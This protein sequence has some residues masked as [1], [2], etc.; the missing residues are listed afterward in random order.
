[1]IKS[2]ITVAVNIIQ[3]KA[4]S[5]LGYFLSI[6]AIIGF[7]IEVS[8]EVKTGSEGFIIAIVMFI[9][10]VL[11]IL[12]GIEIK[13]R[14]KRFR[15]YVSL[16][17]IQNMT[18][19][20]D[21]A[22]NIQKTANFVKTDLQKMIDKKFFVHAV[23]NIKTNQIIIM[24]DPKL[25]EKTRGAVCEYCGA[26]GKVTDGQINECEYCGSILK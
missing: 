17:S 5:V 2:K 1:M 15:K 21:L 11:C 24:I 25:Q 6:F 8:Q 22:V 19:I 20:D 4:A 23:I 10:G 9:I 13:R 12:K 3:G 26:R 16:I 7:S 14:I 18:S